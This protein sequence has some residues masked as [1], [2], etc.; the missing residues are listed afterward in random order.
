[1]IK[2]LL[3]LL[4]LVFAT[5]EYQTQIETEFNAFKSQ[6]KVID[7]VVTEI[8]TA[9]AASPS[10]PKEF[11]LQ[12]AAYLK[13]QIKIARDLLYEWK[14]DTE[15]NYS[16]ARSSINTMVMYKH[17]MREQSLQNLAACARTGK[18]IEA[19]FRRI[20]ARVFQISKWLEEMQTVP[21]ARLKLNPFVDDPASLAAHYT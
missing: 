14:K 4:P 21:M 11:R 6:T 15:S 5:S 19:R 9:F 12:G 2:C 17:A 20:L 18:Q 8:A 13:T 7:D 10:E 16:V 3:L 1:M